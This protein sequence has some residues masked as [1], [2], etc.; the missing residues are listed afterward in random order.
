MVP[1]LRT[2]DEKRSHGSPAWASP[3]RHTVVSTRRP[4]RVAGSSS[5]KACAEP[6]AVAASG[7]RRC[8]ALA[9]C[10]AGVVR[11]LVAST[12]TERGAAASP[13]SSVTTR[14][15]TTSAP[16]ITHHRSRSAMSRISAAGPGWLDP[17]GDAYDDASRASVGR[18]TNGP[19]GSISAASM[20]PTSV[21]IFAQVAP[22]P[23]AR[24][25]CT[26]PAT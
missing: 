21:A 11:E 23:S 1:S 3:A 22:S 16:G 7:T 24:A 14:A 12:G 5:T 10:A 25:T 9:S 4:A 26:T 17:E 2:V 20:W 18:G 8:P 19:A 13:D 6:T 15:I